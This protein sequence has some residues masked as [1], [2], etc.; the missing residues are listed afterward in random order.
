MYAINYIMYVAI[1][2]RRNIMNR[3][4]KIAVFN[5]VVIGITI[6]T[7][8]A[9]IAVLF[10]NYGFPRAY[11]GLGGLGTLGLLGFSQMI[12]RKDKNKVAMDERDTLIM[13]KASLAGF[14][15]SYLFVCLVANAYIIG[16][17]ISGNPDNSISL[18]IL[19]RYVFATIY[20]SV[21]AIEIG[22]CTSVLV[23]YRAG[24]ANE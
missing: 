11:A 19:S 22:R 5:L 17:L 14:K 2:I 6:I 3:S 21:M 24:A 15:A 10:H 1:Y 8:T 12:F 20:G 7:T 4:Q 9:A 23:Q 18:T 16:W 13:T